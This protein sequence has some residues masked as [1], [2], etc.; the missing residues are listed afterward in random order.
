MQL[1]GKIEKSNI[2]YKWVTEPGACKKCKELEGKLFGTLKEFEAARPHPHCKCDYEIIKDDTEEQTRIEEELARAAHQKE[3]EEEQ[4]KLHIQ[5]A[6]LSDSARELYNKIQK[7]IPIIYDEIE[8]RKR[9]KMDKIHYSTM[10]IEEVST[11]INELLKRLNL[12]MNLQNSVSKIIKNIDQMTKNYI[13]PKDLDANKKQINK[14]WQ[15]FCEDILLFIIANKDIA[16]VCGKLYSQG[17][18]LPQAYELF[19][20]G[21]N[22]GDYNKKYIRKNGRLLNKIEDI[23]NLKL[24]YEIKDRILH[25]NTDPANMKVLV[26]NPNS[27]MSKIIKKSG[28]LKNFIKKNM[29][30]LN[31]YGR[32]DNQTIEFDGQNNQSKFTKRFDEDLYASFHGAEVKDIHLDAEGNLHLRIEDLYNFNKNRFS[33]KGRVGRKLQEQGVLKPYYI[34]CPVFIS[35]EELQKY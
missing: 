7:T 31:I 34:I 18:I 20:I 27:S 30:E 3:I 35:K 4:E 24:Q 25:E 1:E 14:N 2:K 11:E 15:Q 33:L 12:A 13:E 5:A 32:L 26:L 29:N 8:N 21:V 6:H 9:I 28:T 16:L 17:F 22:A 10:Q 19:K 23:G